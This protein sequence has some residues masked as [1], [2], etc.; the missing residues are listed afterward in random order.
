VT[1]SWQDKGRVLI[2]DVCFSGTIGER[3]LLG[4]LRLVVRVFV[5]CGLLLLRRL[6]GRLLLLQWGGVYRLRL[7]GVGLG[8]LRVKW[9]FWILGEAGCIG[10]GWV[11]GHDG[12]SGPYDG[13]CDSAGA[14]EELA[15]IH[16]CLF[17]PGVF[18]VGDWGVCAFALWILGCG[19]A[20]FSHVVL[21]FLLC[22]LC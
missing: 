18:C 21:T 3:Y 10:G 5:R 14:A 8:W 7:C 11:D 15:A 13:A 16:P 2:R 19:E 6:R 1:C 22:V 17:F 4:C 12:G 9:R 20:F